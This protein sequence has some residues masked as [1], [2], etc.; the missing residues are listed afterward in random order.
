MLARFD[1]AAGG[2]SISVVVRP[3]RAIKPTLFQVG[4]GAAGTQLQGA[5][6]WHRQTLAAQA[7][8]GGKG[9]VCMH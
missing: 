3:A 2:G 8:Q 5:W 9:C 1:A 7:S 4:G 6:R